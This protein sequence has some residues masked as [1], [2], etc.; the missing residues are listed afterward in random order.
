MIIHDVPNLS[1]SIASDCEKR[2]RHGHEDLTAV[3]EQRV[4]A[5][6]LLDDPSTPSDK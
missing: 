1:R 2:L 3:G 6:R 4:N 5:F